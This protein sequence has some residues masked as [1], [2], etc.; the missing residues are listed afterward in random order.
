LTNQEQECIIILGLIN[1][2]EQL[3]SEIEYIIITERKQES[4]KNCQQVVVQNYNFIA[5]R[6]LSVFLYTLGDPKAQSGLVVEPA[7]FGPFNLPKKKGKGLQLF[8]I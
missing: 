4:I 3:D 5:Y 1:S 7:H 8:M 2:L 6:A